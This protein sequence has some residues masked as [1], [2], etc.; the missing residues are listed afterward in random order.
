MLMVFQA[1][2]AKLERVYDPR[3]SHIQEI[4]APKWQKHV[5]RDYYRQTLS[6]VSIPSTSNFY[7]QNRPNSKSKV[8]FHQPRLVPSRSSTTF[9]RLQNPRGE[10]DRLLKEQI[11]I[12]QQKNYP[13]V[14]IIPESYGMFTNSNTAQKEPKR[15]NSAMHRG[16]QKFMDHQEESSSMN[17]KPTRQVLYTQSSELEDQM[18]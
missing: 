14:N 15:Y 2:T 16:V 17:T 7:Q 12:H 5:D 6:N 13:S 8:N 10:R 11:A 18:F 9:L 4:C 3:D 1:V